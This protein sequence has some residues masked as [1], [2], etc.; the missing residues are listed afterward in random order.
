MR[1][2]I[3]ALLLAVMPVVAMAAGPTQS[4]AV[5]EVLRG[6]FV[7]ERHLKGFNA[8]LRTEG[9]F[10][11]APG[12]GLIWRAE[13][14]FA[15]TTVITANGL[16][17]EVGGSETMRMPSARLPFLSRL[18]DMLGGALAGDWRALETDFVVTRAGDD[19]HWQVDLAPRKA[20]DPIAMPFH[21][22]T[23]QGSRFVETVAMVKPD[24]DSD[25]LSFLDQAL[26]SAPL[27]V[28]ETA[29]LDTLSK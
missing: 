4:I 11:L 9:H 23:A 13:K 2:L 16:V 6:R 22:I 17:Q 24:C 19:R 27:T 20:D 26:S 1:R 25:T 29:A 28:E 8:S 3:L 15:V 12:R 10:V 18:Y 5:G 14:P 21:A 7:Q